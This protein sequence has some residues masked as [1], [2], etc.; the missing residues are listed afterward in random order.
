MV[1]VSTHSAGSR[2]LVTGAFGFVGRWLVSALLE[3]QPSLDIIGCHKRGE[4]AAAADN[5]VQAV[6]LDLTDRDGVFA[7]VRAVRPTCVVHLAAIAAPREASLDPRRAWDVNLFGTMNVADAVLAHE[8]GARFIQISSSEVYGGSF[9]GAEAGLDE[10]AALAPLNMYAVTKAAADLLIGKQVHDGLDAIRFRPFNHSGPG[11]S[12]A[13]VVA[14][15][16]SQI[17]KIERGLAP[18]TLFVGNTDV[19]RDILDVRDVVQAYA[20]AVLLPADHGADLF[21]LASGRSVAI[22]DI[23]DRLRSMAAVRIAVEVDPNRVRANDLKRTLGNAGHAEEVLKW[24]PSI[25]LDETLKDVLDY[26]R[27]RVRAVRT[28]TER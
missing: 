4:A 22:G 19:S 6:A 18:P 3:R 2:I 13:F 28:G 26:W 14:A 15:L 9:D 23:A 24:R 20:S 25:G 12:D 1:T 17:A 27:D 5:R 7:L 16:A 10:S 21:N 8:P 11:Q